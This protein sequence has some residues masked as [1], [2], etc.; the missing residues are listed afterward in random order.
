MKNEIL[1]FFDKNS[2]DIE[3]L[4]DDC[5][6]L[7][8]NG[9]GNDRRTYVLCNILS[10]I[11]K[12]NIFGENHSEF[13]N[14]LI[15]KVSPDSLNYLS[16]VMKDEKDNLINYYKEIEIIQ[17]EK[18]PK[19]VDIEW[20]FIGLASLDKI[21]VNDLEPKIILSLVFNDGSR[22]LIETDFAGFKKL[23]EEIELS[24]GSFN[25]AYAKRINTFAK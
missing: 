1:Q 19:L 2:S 6:I 3:F 25:S 22:K 5:K 4:L 23:Q 21:D 9:K 13:F 11:V 18:I 10:G 20:K 17:K 14:A 16:S 12:D 15:D 24:L 8:A 7:L